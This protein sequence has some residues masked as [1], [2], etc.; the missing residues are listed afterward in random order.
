MAVA[1][2]VSIY[3]RDLPEMSIY[4][5]KNN[6]LDDWTHNKAVQKITESLAVGDEAKR[7][8]RSM[9]RKAGR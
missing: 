6:K 4:Y 7:M 3:Y 9:K 2:A 8:I 1:W 5:L